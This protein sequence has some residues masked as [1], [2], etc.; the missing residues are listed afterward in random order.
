MY[1][2]TMFWVLEQ[3]LI[4]GFSLRIGSHNRVLAPISGSHNAV[5][6]PNGILGLRR[7]SHYGVLGRLSTWSHKEFQS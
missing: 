4:S 3:S 7:G 5:F 2:I 1:I 6:G